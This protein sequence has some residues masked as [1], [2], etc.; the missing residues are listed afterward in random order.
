MKVENRSTQDSNASVQPNRRDL[1]YLFASILIQLLLGY[2]FGHAYDI[3]IFMAT[4]YMVANGYDP[5]ILPNLS[6][7]FHNPAFQ[8]M[9]SIGYPPPWP[10]ILGM[11]YLLS[12]AWMKNFLV[13][14]LAIKLP[15]IAANICLAYLIRYILREQGVS[16]Q[17]SHKAWIFLLLNPFLFYFTTAWGQ[18]DSLVVVL[19]LAALVLLYK[20]KLVASAILLAL[21][22]A[23]KPTPVPIVLVAGFYLW[24]S[25]WKKLVGYGAVLLLSLLALIVLPFLIFGWNASPIYHGWNAQFTVSGGISLAR[26]YLLYADTTVLPGNWWLLGVVWLPAV[27]IA[28]TF[29]RR[30]EHGLLNL[31]QQSLILVLVFYLTRTWLSEQNITLIL[32]LVLVLVYQDKLPKLTLPAVWLLP[33]IFTIFNTS[34]AQL[35]FP[36][37]PQLMAKLLQ[38]SQAY[39]VELL[40]ASMAVIIPWQVAGWWMVINYFRVKSLNTGKT[41]PA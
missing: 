27:F 12:Y 40:W 11:I 21:A 29:L 25:P 13:Y 28:A 23:L 15:I 16:D 8:G 26:L 39:R 37:L 22:I 1:G 14:N 5:Y 7:V 30:G 18:F 17:R 3:K 41:V 36:I 9:S 38:L 20:Q 31:I 10:L 32:P 19:T 4:G 24:G 34:P 6:S 33:L 2:F 35:L